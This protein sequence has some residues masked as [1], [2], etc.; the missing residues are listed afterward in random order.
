M[1][2]HPF[3]SDFRVSPEQQ[4]RFQRD[5]FVKLDG[6]LNA[7][8]VRMLRSRV[9]VEMEQDTDSS[10]LP[11]LYRVK[12]DLE[13]DKNDLFQLL[14][15]LYL[16]QA[17]TD[18]TQSDLFLTDEQIFEV[19]QGANVEQSWH[20]GVQSFGY[21]FASEFGCTLWAPLQPVSASGQ[22]GGMAYVPQHIISGRW[23]FDQIEP[24]VV[25]TLKAKEKAGVK[26]SVADYFAIRFGILNSPAMVEILENHQVE[27]DFEP[28][29]ALLFNKMVVHRSV[30]L[31]E[32]P[33]VKRAAY[34]MRFVDARSHYDLKRAKNLNYPI[35][36]YRKGPFPFKPLTRQ[37]I[38]IAEAG[39]AH[40]DLLSQCAYFS[41][42]DRRMIRREQPPAGAVGFRA[43]RVAATTRTSP[44]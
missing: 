36:Q 37:H 27:D 42:P 6:F 19:E 35:E 29:D 22:R 30:A 17:L 28:G 41:E 25:S 31:M 5:G 39:G 13:S 23:I 8:V 16:R 32:G 38:E 21:Q 44:S 34:V 2:Q 20:V 3:H 43:T 24:A 12:Y 18:L 15:R 1:S 11:S 10:T 40:G 33:L 4:I 14:E 9:E 26:T 7:N